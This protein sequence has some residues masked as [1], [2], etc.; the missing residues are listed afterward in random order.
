[1]KILSLCVGHDSSACVVKNGDV[2]FF[3]EEEK[4]TFNKKDN[5]PVY[6]FKELKKHVGDKV[7][8]YVLTYLNYPNPEVQGIFKIYENYFLLKNNIKAGNTIVDLNHHL[9]HASCAFYSSG[10]KEAIVFVS[11][12]GG[13]IEGN[14][15]S[16][17]FESVFFANYPCK[18]NLL[19]K[20][21][22]T[23]YKKWDKD[24]PN[25]SMGTAFHIVCRMLG[26]NWYD[27][28]KIMGLS[29]YGKENKNIKNFFYKQNDKWLATEYYHKV[30][31][32][33]DHGVNKKINLKKYIKYA[34]DLAYKVQKQSKERSLDKINDIIKKNKIKNFVMTGGY[35]LNCVNNFEYIKAF[36]KINF[37]FDPLANDAGTSLG[38]AKYYWHQFTND[39]KIRP[40]TSLYL[41]H[42]H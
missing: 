8:L 2:I 39:K 28:G 42:E 16:Q 19:D 36:P 17:E 14:W 21:N 30:W 6:L 38:A 5:F 32:Q 26:Y 1:M 11:D 22:F 23:S 12:G 10:F 27:S 41:G 13:K 34:A 4:L 7:D 31:K 18:F 35:A 37:Y 29:A 40:L 15:K 24:N 33:I 25:Y 9:M 20:T 3:M